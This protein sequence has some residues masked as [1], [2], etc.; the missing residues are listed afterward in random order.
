VVAEAEVQRVG[1]EFAVHLMCA[2]E[3]VNEEDMQ[4]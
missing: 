2:V 3:K 1:E 4:K